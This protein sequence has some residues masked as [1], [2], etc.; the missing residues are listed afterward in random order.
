MSLFLLTQPELLSPF[1]IQSALLLSLLQY[2]RTVYTCT[3][4]EVHTVL[5]I[6]EPWAVGKQANAIWCPVFMLSG[7]QVHTWEII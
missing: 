3:H 1:V 2:Y 7:S 5:K 4:T 6:S